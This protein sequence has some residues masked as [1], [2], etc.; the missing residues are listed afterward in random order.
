MNAIFHRVPG[1]A[2]GRNFAATSKQNC[3]D[4][5][6]PSY[7]GKMSEKLASQIL[8]KAEEEQSAHSDR[9][10]IPYDNSKAVPGIGHYTRCAAQLSDIYRTVPTPIDGSTHNLSNDCK[11]TSGFYSRCTRFGA[12]PT[13]TMP[14]GSVDRFTG[15][16][17]NSVLSG[18]RSENGARQ[19]VWK[20]QEVHYALPVILPDQPAGV[21]GSAGARFEESDFLPKSELLDQEIVHT[22]ELR[23]LGG[24]DRDPILPM[25]VHNYNSTTPYNHSH[26]QHGTDL[27]AFSQSVLRLQ[28]QDLD[29]LGSGLTGKDY[30]HLEQIGLTSGGYVDTVKLLNGR[31]FANRP[32]LRLT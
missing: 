21:A 1:F 15:A 4:Y 12:C 14:T 24:L 8:D 7:S 9:L 19:V 13:L 30:P 27:K 11:G 20:H 10:E 28:Q 3:N 17:V 32:E 23:D 22:Y 2:S 29:A 26:Y 18:E 25:L 6:F 16:Q 5:W 31:N